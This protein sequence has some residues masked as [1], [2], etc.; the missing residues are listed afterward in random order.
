M[1][2][3]YQFF[4]IVGLFIVQFDIL[5][6]FSLGFYE[7]NLLLCATIL[8]GLFRGVEAGSV[9]GL[10]AGLL[11]DVDTGL[12]LGAYALSWTQVGF[13]SAIIGEKLL[14]DNRFVQMI[15]VGIG[16]LLAGFFQILFYRL[17]YME[18]PLWILILKNVSQ[19]IMSTLFTIPLSIL[20]YRLDVIP[21]QRHE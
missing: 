7:P 15:A 13:T 8:I 17:S 4:F 9:T 11:S 6:R 18:D 14:I 2:L 21:R 20:L 3:I 5:P 16:C 10:L 19:S 1:K 12:I